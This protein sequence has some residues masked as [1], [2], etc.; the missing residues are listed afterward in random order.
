MTLHLLLLLGGVVALAVLITII[1]SC[2]FRIGDRKRRVALEK[3]EK[4]VAQL[5]HD[6]AVTQTPRG[7]MPGAA[8]SAGGPQ[9]VPPSGAQARGAAPQCS[10]EMSSG[11][12]YPNTNQPPSSPTRMSERSQQSSG[13]PS[14]C[15]SVL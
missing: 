7:Q 6:N 3:N 4:R 11:P 14:L 2:S 9:R 8:V 12:G 10:M 15:S 1:L 13:R 5:Q